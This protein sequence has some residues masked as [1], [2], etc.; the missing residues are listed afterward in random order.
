MQTLS[1]GW[2]LWAPG[3]GVYEA[4][5]LVSAANTYLYHCL[6]L[7]IP[8]LP[9]ISLLVGGAQHLCCQQLTPLPP[10]RGVGRT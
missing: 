3:I 2:A 5:L 7:S 10:E 8:W 9:R 1:G 6:L 4:E